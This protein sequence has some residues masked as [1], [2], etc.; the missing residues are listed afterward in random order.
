MFFVVLVSNCLFILI[1]VLFV[2]CNLV[3]IFKIVVL[4]MLDG[5]WI[6]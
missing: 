4:L 3:I 6:V 2:L 1:I 5:L